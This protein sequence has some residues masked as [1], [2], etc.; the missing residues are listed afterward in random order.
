MRITEWV[1]RQDPGLDSRH[2][3]EQVVKNQELRG[4]FH[5]FNRALA[6]TSITYPSGAIIN[7][8]GQWWEKV[9]RQQP[10]ALDVGEQ[11][12]KNHLRAI[13]SST[14]T[15]TVELSTMEEHQAVFVAIGSPD[16]ATSVIEVSYQR[17]GKGD[18]KAMEPG[19]E[20]SVHTGTNPSNITF[21]VT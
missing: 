1:K 9:A 18:W 14:S 4:V 19:V 6:S 8:T 2:A 5:G 10:L 21:L 12:T 3:H 15:Y 17:D 16:V 20:E 11:F 13:S 7:T